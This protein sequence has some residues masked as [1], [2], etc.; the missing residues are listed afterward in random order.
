MC[1]FVKYSSNISKEFF[2]AGESSTDISVSIFFYQQLDIY[3]GKAKVLRKS[4][5]G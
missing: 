1:R 2:F 4:A 5:G 3:D